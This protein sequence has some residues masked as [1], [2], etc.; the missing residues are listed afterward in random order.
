MR[1]RKRKPRTIPAS[2]VNE[3]FVRR[4][5][6]GPLAQMEEDDAVEQF[7]RNC[8]YRAAFAHPIA[9]PVMLT[10]K[11]KEIEDDEREMCHVRQVSRGRK[12]PRP[13]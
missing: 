7:I 8:L 10:D 4:L 11:E 3:G 5:E 2:V 12:K 6:K 9:A 13:A 1:N